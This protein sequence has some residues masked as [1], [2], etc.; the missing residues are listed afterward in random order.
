MI[1]KDIT[2]LRREFTRSMLYARPEELDLITSADIQVHDVMLKARSMEYDHDLKHTWVTISRWNALIR[3]YLDPDSVEGWLGMIE[4]K[5]QGRKRGLSFMR[6]KQ[7]AMRSN[8]KGREWRRWGS[9]MLGFGYRAMPHPTLT[10]HSRTT[11][12]GYIGELDLALAHVLAREIAQ[13]VGLRVEDIRFTW[14]IE[15]AQFHNFKSM[16]WWFHPDNTAD[17]ARL[18]KFEPT[19]KLK[20]RAPGLYYSSRQLREERRRDEEGVGYGDMT[21]NQQLR[22]RRRYHTEVMGEGYGKQFE[23]GTKNTSKSMTTAAPVLPSVPVSTLTLDPVMQAKYRGEDSLGKVGLL[24]DDDVDL[25]DLE[26]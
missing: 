15:A 22:I 12:M 20:K 6:T 2:E 18:E 8:N 5:L 16:A 7:V 1:Y 25:F 4:A 11:Y 14:F 24:E 9:C 19:E 21:F 13:R 17:L 10:M 3:Q 26:A 23:H